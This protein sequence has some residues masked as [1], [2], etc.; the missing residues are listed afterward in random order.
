M[1]M[2]TVYEGPYTYISYGHLL[3]GV[4][5]KKYFINTSEK[6]FIN[7]IGVSLDLRLSVTNILLIKILLILGSV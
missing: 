1:F 7:T 6:C 2:P 3:G 5:D 4:C